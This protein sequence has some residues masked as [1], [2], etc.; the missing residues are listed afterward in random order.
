MRLV[1]VLDEHRL[2]RGIDRTHPK[3]EALPG[4][5]RAVVDLHAVEPGLHRELRVAHEGQVG[6]G[7]VAVLDPTLAADAV[8]GVPAHL[9]APVVT[10]DLSGTLGL[11]PYN[12][13]RVIVWLLGVAVG[14]EVLQGRELGFVDERRAG[15]V[16]EA[17]LVAGAA[18]LPVRS[19]IA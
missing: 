15:L 18:G 16:V 1:A 10:S 5:A 6:P 7:P 3:L 14:D 4:A 12:G 11:T 8:A 9:H 2:A 19:Y 17:A 13:R